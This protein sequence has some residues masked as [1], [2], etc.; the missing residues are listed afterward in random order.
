MYIYMLILILNRS[1]SFVTVSFEEIGDKL[2]FKLGETFVK[3]C[4]NSGSLESELGVICI[5]MKI[6]VIHTEANGR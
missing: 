4:K 2:G 3:V 6:N 5:A 1:H